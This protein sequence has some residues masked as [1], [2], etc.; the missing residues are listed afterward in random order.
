MLRVETMILIILL[1]KFNNSF[2]YQKLIN[3]TVLI[4]NNTNIVLWKDAP[5]PGSYKIFGEA[6]GWNGQKAKTG[7]LNITI[8]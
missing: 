1:N 2:T 8:K 7:E 4:S 5:I 6:I 3:S